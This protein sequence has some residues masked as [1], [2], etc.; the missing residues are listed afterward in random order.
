MCVCVEGGG[1]GAEEGQKLKTR[2]TETEVCL[3]DTV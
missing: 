2:V 1:R 3:E